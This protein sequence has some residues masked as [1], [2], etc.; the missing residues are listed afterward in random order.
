[1]KYSKQVLKPIV[2]LSL[3]SIL[4]FSNSCNVKPG[5]LGAQYRIFVVADSV[6]WQKVE[7]QVRAIFEKELVTPH[8][9]KSYFIT[10]IPLDKLN[11]L[12][13]RMN[14]FFMGI[15]NG[16]GAVDQYLTKY[17]PQN[18]RQGVEDGNFFYSFI[19]N[20]FARDQISLIMMAKDE[21]ALSA[22]LEAMKNEMYRKFTEKYYARLKKTMFERDENTSVQKYLNKHFGWS[23]KLQQDY[24]IAE[25]NQD[26]K[27]V[28][29]RRI[30]PNRWISI[31]E[32]E[33]NADSLGLDTLKHIRT[34]MARKYYQG[35]IVVNEDL[36]LEKVDFN[37]YPAQKMTGLWQN[38]SLIVGG[39]FRLYT[40]KDAQKGKRYFIDIAVMAPGE[41]KKPYLDQLEVMAHTF[42]T[43][44]QE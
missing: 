43:N 40:Y 12:N 16:D 22:N 4:F 19:K 41:L 24:F 25:E 26:A 18:F 15:L 39:P 44:K 33:S 28:W 8:T 7:P 21:Q 1:M 13:D 2:L 34:R 5:T 17:M 31:W 30:R 11:S 32:T 35:D 9:E 37:G 38:D 42:R 27:Y 20:M 36:S 14:V 10:M 23:I 3:F 6:L 29:L